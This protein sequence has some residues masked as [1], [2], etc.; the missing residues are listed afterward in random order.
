MDNFDWW[1]FV[2]SS[3]LVAYLLALLWLDTFY[4]HL[5]LHVFNCYFYLG[6]DLKNI[7][8][9]F[10]EW[11]RI[12]YLYILASTKY[13]LYGPDTSKSRLLLLPP[14]IRYQIWKELIPREECARGDKLFAVYA[15]SHNFSWWKPVSLENVLRSVLRL[16]PRPNTRTSPPIPMAFLR[17]CR[18]IYDE[19]AHFY[20]GTSTF[21]VYFEGPK[22]LR[23][24]WKSCSP[25][26]RATIRHIRLA[27]N[28]LQM[29]QLLSPDDIPKPS[30][31]GNRRRHLVLSVLRAL[32]I[33]EI[34]MSLGDL[35]ISIEGTK[36]ANKDYFILSIE[37]VNL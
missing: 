25:S 24:F 26:Q 30:Y 5:A 20:Y 35:D 1:C 15:G 13:R 29:L 36:W 32:S 19:G 6:I 7:T 37:R 33:M 11:M 3:L 12:R 27:I 23:N 14:E 31:T 2:F 22:E 17:T 28:M 8:V 4:I 34:L 16:E 21:Y 18:Q 10:T 9:A